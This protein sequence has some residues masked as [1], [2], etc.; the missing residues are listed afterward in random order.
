MGIITQ[1]FLPLILAFIMFSMGLSLVWGDFKRIATQPKA[2]AVGALCQVVLLPLVAFILISFWPLQPELA[3]GV[4]ILAAC[5]GGVVS[6]L[7]THLAKGDSALSISLTAVISLVSMI[8]IPFV[9]NF[10]LSHFAGADQAVA[11]PVGKTILGIFMITTV[12]VLLGMWV[13][14]HHPVLAQLFEPRARKIATLLFVLMVVGAVAKERNNMLDYFIQA[15]PITLVLN[16][17]MMTLAFQ[18]AKW[19]KLGRKEGIAISLECGLQNGTLAIMVAATFLQNTAMTIPGAI[20]SLIMFGTSGIFIWILN[21]SAQPVTVERFDFSG[22]R[23]YRLARIR[24]LR[25]NPLV[26]DVFGEVGYAK[27]SSDVTRSRNN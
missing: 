5:P 23:F 8:S 20:Y 6:N 19:F 2:F 26:E 9:V 17:F 12:P 18:M 16:V 14:H 10:S 25:E 15:G 7:L 11:L 3:V 21:R 13:N 4:M 27:R 1:V 22:K 24:T